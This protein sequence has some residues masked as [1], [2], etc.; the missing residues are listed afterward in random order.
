MYR[1][2]IFCSADL[3]TN[4]S[5]EEFPVGR[6]LA[7]N[8][9]KGRLWAVCRK[10]GR[11][12]LAPIEERWEAV[13]SA[14]KTFRDSRLRVHSENIGL[15]KLPDGTRLI[16]VGEAL[17]GEM[18]AWRY[19]DQLLRRRRQYMIAG[20]AVAAVGV[21]AVGGI[22]ALGVG[23]TLASMSGA[24]GSA[25][26]QWQRK[27]VV[28][29]IPA[30]M[31]PTGREIT[32]RRWHVQGAFLGEARGGIALHI[33]DVE[34][35]K[36]R[37]STW[38]DQ[39]RYS[40]QILTLDDAEARTVLGRAMVHVNKKGAS[41]GRV[42]EAIRELDHARTAEDYLALVARKGNVL[43]K[44]KGMEERKLDPVQALTLEMA[45]HEES[46]RRALEGELALLEARWRE[47]EEIAGI[48]DTLPDDPLD[49]LKP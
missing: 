27:K 24:L 23:G 4:E 30:G 45:L 48:A 46:E 17:P 49:R 47:A 35:E 41:R 12:N 7:F 18:A 32:V 22:L 39:V 34:R 28:H 5:I 8:A 43:G 26:E 3:G 36:P 33:P 16:R 2:C 29:R 21:A 38:S 13:E 9:W 40:D 19:G 42:R 1:T 37:T 31:S 14:E 44:R 6:S 25:W 15:C 10:C 20:A 11:W